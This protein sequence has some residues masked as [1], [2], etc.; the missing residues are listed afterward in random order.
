M[1]EI[2][3]KLFSSFK[4]SHDTNGLDKIHKTY[5]YSSPKEDKSTKLDWSG[6]RKFKFAFSSTALGL[7]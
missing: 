7:S 6:S 4:Y 1:F 2:G 5:M 3:V